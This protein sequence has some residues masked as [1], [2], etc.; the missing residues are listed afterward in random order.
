M[1]TRNLILLSATL[2]LASGQQLV[3]S[4]IDVAKDFDEAIDEKR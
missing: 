4:E 2:L 3:N 1:K